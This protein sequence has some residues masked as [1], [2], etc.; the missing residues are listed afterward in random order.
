MEVFIFTGAGRRCAWSA[1]QKARIVA[2]SYE[3][4]ESVSAVAAQD[5][6]KT[7]LAPP[8]SKRFYDGASA[9]HTDWSRRCP[10]PGRPDT[11]ISGAPMMPTF[12]RPRSA[13]GF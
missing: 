10:S 12:S 7:A 9:S 8:P 2:E 11:G 1:E 5:S 3:I 13:A 4:G 6:S